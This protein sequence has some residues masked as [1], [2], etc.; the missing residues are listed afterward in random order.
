MV[1]PLRSSPAAV[2]PPLR[3]Q[4]SPIIRIRTAMM[5]SGNTVLVSS[6]ARRQRAAA[7]IWRRVSGS[8]PSTVVMSRGGPGAA[9][10]RRCAGPPLYQPN[11]MVVRATSGAHRLLT[12]PRASLW[13]VDGEGVVQGVAV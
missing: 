9:G 8:A 11:V 4:T 1:R 7:V 3:P 5:I 10:L 13:H 6:V 12:D 2:E